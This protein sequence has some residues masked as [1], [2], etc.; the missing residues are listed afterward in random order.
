MN[1]F[2]IHA[3]LERLPCTRP[4]LM[5][6]QWIE[7][8]AAVQW[9]RWMIQEQR[10]SFKLFTDRREIGCNITKRSL[11]FPHDVS[12]GWNWVKGR[13]ETNRKNVEESR[14]SAE[15]EKRRAS[16]SQ[17]VW[18]QSNCWSSSRAQAHWTHI[19]FFRLKHRQRNGSASSATHC[20]SH[21][22]S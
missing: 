6:L 8:T 14:S 20:K 2:S 13:R 9:K 17:L 15:A 16:W 11:Y 5:A 22:H 10:N 12:G 19:W 21:I 4:T 18:H 7:N 1:S 3:I